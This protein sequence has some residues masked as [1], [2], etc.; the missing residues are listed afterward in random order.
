MKKGT[1]GRIVMLVLAVAIM[2]AVPFLRPA[3][4]Y[5][6][7][8]EAYSLIRQSA[9]LSWYDSLSYGG[10]IYP[11]SAGLPMLLSISPV[12]ISKILP[13]LS[14]IFML[15]FIYLILKDKG[16]ECKEFA[17]L[18]AAASPPMLYLASTLSRFSIPLVLLL[19]G[20]Y[21]LEKQEIS[22]KLYSILF[23][24]LIPLFDFAF[25]IIAL[26]MLLIYASLNKRFK[27]VAWLCFISML[28]VIA[29]FAGYAISKAGLPE[30][31]LFSALSPGINGKL[32]M[33]IAELGALAGLS[34]FGLIA[35]TI[36]IRNNWKK[37]YKSPFMFFS[38][39]F[40]AVMSFFR[41]E[42]LMILNIFV[43]VFAALG[44]FTIM[45][46]KFE[47]DIVKML[48]F[49]VLAC[50]LVFSGAM[51]ADRISS[52]LPDQSIIMG[53]SALNKLPEGTV[54]SHYDR[55]HWIS[56]AGHKNVMD[57]NFLFAP[58]VNERWIDSNTLLSIRD[59][60]KAR[61]IFDKYNIRYIWI[62]AE[63]K[64]KLWENDE[65]GLLFLLKYSGSIEK[66]YDHLGVE[67]WEVMEEED[68]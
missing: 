6:P 63:M 2:V 68:S 47:S 49:F 39:A 65:D 15:L 51:A 13:T 10:R 57:D 4:N 64:D 26:F 67:I 56:F 12:L 37:K 59:I 33:V 34:L 48:T 27:W 16:L 55:G 38:V 44:I 3:E 42:P 66:R 14:V 62:D 19:A 25:G 41:P 43:S 40:L 45:G 24:G 52:S 54:Y 28:L 53:I 17:V 46:Q 61:E 50:G 60:K 21:F 58:S 11:Y 22:L 18:V 31:V 8:T 9:G 1:I 20:Y 36:G 5:F 29:I 7:G 23:L 30:T 35:A 32:M